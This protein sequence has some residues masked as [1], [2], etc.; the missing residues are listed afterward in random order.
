MI[1]D[2]TRHSTKIT[3]A[4]CEVKEG[5]LTYQNAIYVPDHAPLRLR[6][7]QD[8]HDPPT[9]G[10]PGK[11]KTYELLSK[12]LLLAHNAKRRPAI[13]QTLPHLPTYKAHKT[14]PVWS[15]QRWVGIFVL[16]LNS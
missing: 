11:A 5:K 7:I 2:K 12:R 10:H 16:F 3:L 9:M 14:R 13:R 4:D 8:H 1:H 15:P 6:L